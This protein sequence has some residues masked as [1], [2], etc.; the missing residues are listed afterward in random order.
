M[1]QMRPVVLLA[2][3]LLAACSPSNHAAE[4]VHPMGDPVQAGPLV[5]T[6]LEAD[7]LNQL[8]SGHEAKWPKNR[9][10]VVRLSIENIG[11]KEVNLPLLS[12]LNGN[13][14][15]TLELDNGDG[16]DEWLGLMR[17][18]TPATTTH[19]KIVF[20]VPSGNY[21]LRLTNGAS[22]EDEKFSYVAIPLKLNALSQ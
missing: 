1:N 15:E 2:L 11:N 12:V 4:A 20:D 8:G 19:G 14:Q 5:Y 13:K 18:I 22:P 9:F 3:A 16:V 21:A 10:L 6:V 17:P 7:W